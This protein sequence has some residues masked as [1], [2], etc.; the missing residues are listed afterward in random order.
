MARNIIGKHKFIILFTI[1][2]FALGLLTYKDYGVTYDERVEY[3]AGKYLL[4]YLKLPTAFEYVEQLI[5]NRP[6]NI[7]HRQLP[8]LSE[9][10]R[11][12]PALLNLLNPNYYFEW[13]HL[14][15]IFFGYFLFFFA[16]LLFYLVYK[17]GIKAMV[18]PVLLFFTPVLL[19]H[20]PANPKD[21][22]FATVYLLGILALSYFRGRTGSDPVRPLPVEILA[23]GLIFGAA[24]SLRT[25]GITLFVSY[26]LLEMLEAIQARK[27][28]TAINCGVKLTVILLVSAFVWI[29]FV[30]FLGANFFAN[31]AYT[32]TN[33]AV[34]KSW[35][36]EVFYLGKYLLKDQRPWHYLF[37]YLAVN[38]P[39]LELAALAAG[40]ILIA[41]KKLK[42]AK[43]HPINIIALTLLINTAI[44]LALHPVVYNG[45]RH[46][47]YLVAELVLVS[48]F[49][50][51]EMFDTLAKKAKP[52]MLM[53]AATY[54]LFTIVRMIHLHP[55]EYIY[56]NEFVGGIKGAENL[57][58]LDY[59]GAAYKESAQYVLKVVKENDLKNIKVYA[60][61][62]QFAVV[63]Y[64]QFQYSLVARSRD[65]DVIICDTFKEKLRALQGRDFYRDSHP[66]V[67]TIQREGT[68]IHN[69]RARQELKELF[70]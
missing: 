62:N 33:A 6:V 11:V 7:E 32:L 30:P 15:N 69:I 53:G 34:F 48:G 46:F 39:V 36:Y 45:I 12:Y 59:W 28:A 21:I 2:Y 13:F 19:G 14:Q 70:M 65:A 61:D 47:L 18:G 17:N 1:A 3:D 41:K 24:Q 8:L 40:A 16:Y 60:C 44:Y 29:L 68:S 57:F 37:G 27:A 5:N 9:Y 49:F 66:I 38:L 25:V 54:L 43:N 23:L 10:S 26:A 63:Y 4:T 42:F 56:Y 52:V 20:V 51:I 58:E 67:R 31:A 64:S 50:L 22:P 35:D 55:Y